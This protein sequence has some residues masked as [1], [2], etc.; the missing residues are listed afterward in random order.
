MGDT[1]MW[2][3]NV[4]WI[5]RRGPSAAS[6][7]VAMALRSLKMNPKSCWDQFAL[8]VFGF[9]E[10]IHFQQCWQQ[11]FYDTMAEPNGLPST[12][13]V[14][15]N[16]RSHRSCCSLCQS[17]H[18]FAWMKHQWLKDDEWRTDHGGG[19]LA[20]KAAWKRRQWQ[21]ARPT[22]LLF[23]FSFWMPS[24]MDGSSNT[25]SAYKHGKLLQPSLTWW[26]TFGI[27]G[28]LLQHKNPFCDE[29]IL[30]Q[31][32]RVVC[33]RAFVCPHHSIFLTLQQQDMHIFGKTVTKRWGI[34]Y[35]Y[36]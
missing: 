13:A 20:S 34:G 33:P 6:F 27:S 32:L 1:T 16:S 30:T 17:L 36:T 4:V 18:S 22:D 11:F 8:E 3:K 25:M 28:Q 5:F 12:L 26:K 23:E 15:A 35:C 29:I 10:V 14:A 7:V 19:K 9:L 2:S 21:K 31:F 24:N